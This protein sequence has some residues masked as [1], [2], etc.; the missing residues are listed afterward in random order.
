MIQYYGRTEPTPADL[1]GES[2]FL[3][4]AKRVGSFIGGPQYD[5]ELEP[6][7]GA[8]SVES[9]SEIFNVR[10]ETNQERDTKARRFVA[11][12]AA[13]EALADQDDIIFSIRRTLKNAIGEMGWHVVPDLDAVKDELKQWEAVVAAK[14]ALPGLPLDFVPKAMDL[15]IYKAATG[16]LQEMLVD[17]LTTGVD[18]SDLAGN[19]RYRQFFENLVTAHDAV[20]RSHISQVEDFLKKPN[21]SAE[22]SFRAMLDLICDDVTLFDSGSV[23]KNCT[24]DGRLGEIYTLPGDQ[25]EIYRNKDK[26]TPQPPYI[27]YHWIEDG[28]IKALFNNLELMMI[29]AN[30]QKSGYGKSPIEVLVRQMIGAQFADAY[31]IDWFQNSN[32][33]FFVFDLGPGVQPDERDAVERRWDQRVAAGRHRGIFVANKEG[34][35]GFLPMPQTT[36]KDAD[37]MAQMKFWANRK[38]AAFGLSLNDIGFTE[39]LHRTTAETQADLTQ[40]RGVASFGNVIESY[41][42]G[43][44]V[45]GQMWVRN[46]PENPNDL[47]GT[48]KPC[49][50]FRDVKFK[51][52]TDETEER[53]QKATALAPLLANGALC[54]NEVRDELDLAHVPG[55]D[56]CVVFSAGSIKVRDLPDLPGPMEAAGQLPSPDGGVEGSVPGETESPAAIPPGGSGGGQAALGKAAASITRLAKRLAGMAK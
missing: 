8:G 55:G 43:E 54:I 23:V 36:N 2:P 10:R 38:C 1:R 47:T 48:A 32:M 35:K 4:L 6:R 28:Q 44:I 5:P 21:P 29:M 16:P 3:R 49:F 51:F 24:M 18:P 19:H 56:E 17:L 53:I 34:V 14:I 9:L 27:A 52:F 39:D 31:L 15:K 25:I 40:S 22:S 41:L 12:P 30:P 13:L 45:Q 7:K 46:D 33:P 50:P 42:N 20:A 11:P 26:S 37:V